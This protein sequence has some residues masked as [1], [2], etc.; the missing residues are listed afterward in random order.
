M[1]LI[2][3]CLTPLSAV[4]QQDTGEQL[5]K[6]WCAQCHGYDGDGN[7]YAKNYTFPQPRDFTIGTYKFRSTP[8]GD[9]PVDEDIIRSIR[10]GNPGTSMPAWTRFSDEEVR[11]IVEY[12]KGFAPDV[13]ELETEPIKIQ[14]PPYSDE[15]IKKG[16]E[17]FKIAK[18]VECHGQEGR[19]NGKKGWEENFRDDWG[20][21]IYPANYTYPWEL[22]NGSTVEDIYR[23]ITTGLSGT[24]MTSYQDSLSDEERWA[25]AYFIKS[26]QVKRRLGVSLTIK[27]V[28]EIPETTDDPLWDSIEYLDL[29]MGGQ[30]IFE[31]RNFTPVITNVRVRG[32]Y[33]ADK[34]AIML[35]WVDKKPDNGAPPDAVRIQF[36]KEISKGTEKPYF[37]MGDR[38]H[39]VNLWWWK[40]SD[41]KAVEYIAKGHE[42]FYQQEVQDVRAVSKYQEGLYRVIF[43]RRLKTDDRDDTVFEVGRFIPFS[44]A[45]F[46]GRE[47][48]EGIKCAIS[49]WYYLILEPETG[50]KVY[51]LPPVVSLVVFGIGFGLHRRLS[52]QGA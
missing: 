14:P 43:I 10:Q 1:L 51:I 52:R 16:R 2:I 8:T 13:F 42:N 48:E 40:A 21:R 9:P 36:P 31:P 35:E 29:P 49:A 22:R 45:A 19:G 37:F 38:R 39:P 33:T 3:V 18:C 20:N 11:S 24:P 34:I 26:L 17:L 28:E 4:A 44:V 7:G 12:I 27:R 46:D 50:A 25:L 41:G 15:L 32:V 30:L 47:K 5:Y 23:T 6:Q